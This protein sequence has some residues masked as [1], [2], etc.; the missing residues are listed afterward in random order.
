MSS[1]TDLYGPNGEEVAD[2]IDRCGMVTFDQARALGNVVEEI[3][4]DTLVAFGA[5]AQKSTWLV[6]WDQ[7]IREISKF[8][9]E[10]EVCRAIDNATTPTWKLAWDAILLAVLA[11]AARD[12]ISKE[13][14]DAL[15]GPWASVMEVQE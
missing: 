15:Y 12:I 1:A 3:K 14:F 8:G 6:A 11:L 5:R 2:F 4:I 10:E 13:Q 7:T 9:R